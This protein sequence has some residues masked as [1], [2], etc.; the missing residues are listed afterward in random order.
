MEDDILYVTDENGNE[1]ESRI[2]M[3]FD[4]AEFGKS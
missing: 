2:I 3:T 1:L 4:S